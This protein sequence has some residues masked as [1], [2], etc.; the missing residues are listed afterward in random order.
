MDLWTLYNG[1]INEY[2]ILNITGHYMIFID[3]SGSNL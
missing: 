1:Q 3:G 2:I